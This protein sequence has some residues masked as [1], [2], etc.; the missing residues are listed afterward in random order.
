[1]QSIEMHGLAEMMDTL[2]TIPDVIR[3]ARREVMDSMGRELL[4]DVRRRIGGTG[5]VSDVQEYKV[6]SGTGYVAVRPAAQTYLGRYAA[7]SVTNAL[8]NGHA[9]RRPT[10]ASGRSRAKIAAVPGKYMY[11]ETGE[12]DAER[13]AESAAREIESVIISNSSS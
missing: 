11:R 12:A 2:E 6:G 8:E 1:M 7:G 9:I 10:S 13:L 3:E 4:T 5:R